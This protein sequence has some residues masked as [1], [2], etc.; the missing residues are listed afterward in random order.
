MP[1][2]SWCA[3]YLALFFL[4]LTIQGI[5]DIAS[6]VSSWHSYYA[7]KT[8][9]MLGLSQELDI[10]AIVD[11]TSHVAETLLMFFHHTTPGSMPIRL[12]RG[13]GQVAGARRSWVGIGGYQV[14]HRN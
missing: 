14:P 6:W 3:I 4:L 11:E 2:R 12:I 10:S 7:S 13:G 9:P 5:Y 1:K 8:N